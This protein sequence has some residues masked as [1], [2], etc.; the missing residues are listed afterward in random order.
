MPLLDHFHP[1]LSEERHWEG[2][3]SKWSNVLVD[4]LNQTQLPAGYFA[5]PRRNS[6]RPPSARTTP[7][8]FPDAFAVHVHAT[9]TPPR[10]TATIQF[11]SPANKSQ[12]DHRRALAAR[13]ARYLY[14]GIGL[15]LIDIVTTEGS[16]L[17][18]EIFRL[19][20]DTPP[21]GLLPAGASLYAAAYRHLLRDNE[22]QVW[23]E[24][25]SLGQPLPILPLWLT[26]DICLPI[27]LGSTYED[28]CRRLR[29]N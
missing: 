28:S 21:P 14:Q 7:V 18:D 8:A 12:A 22:L 11:V 15:I 25:L 20:R 13:C 26:G 2:F 6:G 10:L 16:D 24:P 1:P 27:N 4:E 19:L 9:E 29:L 17:N 3:H 5:E 23:L